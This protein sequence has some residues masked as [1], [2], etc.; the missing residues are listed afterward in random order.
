MILHCHLKG[1]FVRNIA[2]DPDRL[3]IASNTKMNMASTTTF[4]FIDTL[5]SYGMWLY[6]A[7]IGT[8][9]FFWRFDP[10]SA[11]AIVSIA[12]LTFGGIILM[13]QKYSTIPDMLPKRL[14]ALQMQF[15]SIRFFSWITQ[16][17]PIMIIDVLVYTFRHF[18]I[19]KAL[20][21][22]ISFGYTLI[23]VAIGFC[24]GLLSMMPMGLG[25]Y[26]LSIVFM[27]MHLGVP[28]ESAVLVP[29]IERFVMLLTSVIFGS[30]SLHKLHLSWKKIK[31]V[32]VYF[33][34]K[35]SV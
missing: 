19:F 14:G 25:G 31:A 18:L 1:R 4:L 30:V 34:K 33:G 29:V 24:G 21:I 26:D 9:L 23:L 12:F 7:L 8:L 10:F 27:L 11:I 16:A 15:S 13:L 35:V 28:R 6:V 32:P 2:A 20:D 17:S 22:Q 3:G 5:L